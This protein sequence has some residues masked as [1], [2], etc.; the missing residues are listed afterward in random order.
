MTATA[1]VLLALAGC[2]SSP[3][4]DDHFGE[5]VRANLSAQVANPA[6]SN[7]ANPALGIDGHAAR[8]AQERYQKSFAQPEA[9]TKPALIL[10]SGQ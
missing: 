10:G 9:E 1:C 5:A 8:A 4:I 2:S 6:A 3:R 7:N